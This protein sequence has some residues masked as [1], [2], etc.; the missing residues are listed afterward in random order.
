MQAANDRNF[1]IEHI[2]NT[3]YRILDLKIKLIMIG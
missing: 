1:D 3:I 2:I